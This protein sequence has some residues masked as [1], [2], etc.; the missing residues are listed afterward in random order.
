MLYSHGKLNPNCAGETFY[1]FCVRFIS[2]KVFYW[3]EM[4]TVL[5]KTVCLFH[6]VSI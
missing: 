2:I 6:K 4:K 5:L 1:E 3:F